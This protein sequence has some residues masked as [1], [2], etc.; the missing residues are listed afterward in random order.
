MYP[1]IFP[2]EASNERNKRSRG[3]RC[4]DPVLVHGGPASNGRSRRYRPWS[5]C[6][7]WPPWCRWYSAACST[8]VGWAGASC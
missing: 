5:S 4:E 6:W 1:R 7:S 2:Q 3:C 8:G